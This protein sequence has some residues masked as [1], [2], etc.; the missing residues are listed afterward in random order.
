M[1]KFTWVREN[2]LERDGRKG[3]FRFSIVTNLNPNSIMILNSITDRFNRGLKE[4]L[5]A[6]ALS[7]NGWMKEQTNG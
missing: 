2:R 3:Q 7:I 4:N 6:I 1:Y 5:K